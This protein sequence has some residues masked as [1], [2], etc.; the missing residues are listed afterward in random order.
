MFYLPDDPAPKFG[1][2]WLNYWSDDHDGFDFE[3]RLYVERALHRALK[4]AIPK[5]RFAILG[6]ADE[7]SSK[8]EKDCLDLFITDTLEC[9]W[10]GKKVPDAL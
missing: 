2:I 3:V 7:F 5:L 6:M 9:Y 4:K 8:D 10:Q 1:K